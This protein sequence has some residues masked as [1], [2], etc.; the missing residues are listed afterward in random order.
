MV[1]ACLK[2]KTITQRFLYET[3]SEFQVGIVHNQDTPLFP[4]D[5]IQLNVLKNY[6]T[7]TL[8]ATVNTVSRMARAGYHR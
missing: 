7:K 6:Y 3:W 5:F 8:Y 4:A 1:Y 2:E